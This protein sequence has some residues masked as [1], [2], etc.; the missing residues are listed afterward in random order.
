[1]ADTSHHDH[2]HTHAHEGGCCGPTTLSHRF[3]ACTLN[4]SS[5]MS[6]L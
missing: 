4:L 3:A 1:M 2:S 6:A 5:G